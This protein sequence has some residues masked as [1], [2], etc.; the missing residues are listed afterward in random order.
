MI[1]HR[2][3]FV[4]VSAAVLGLVAV[5][6]VGPAVPASADPPGLVIEGETT[7]SDSSDKS[8]K[9]NCPGGTVVTGG[10]GYL[11]TSQAAEPFVALDRLEPAGDGTGFTATMREVAVYPGTW[12]HTA[13]A[14]C[15]PEPPGWAV[16]SNTGANQQQYVTTPTCGTGRN[17]IGI[18][19]RINGGSGEVILEDLTPSFDLE[20]VTV[21]GVAIPGGDDD[22]WTVTAYAVCA[23]TPPGLERIAFPV[24]QDSSAE[25]TAVKSCPAG[26]ALYGAG[27]AVNNGDGN[28]LLNGVNIA[29][30][31]TVRAWAHE[32]TGGYGS[33]WNLT[34]YGICGS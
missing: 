2:Q 34:A 1:V 3:V 24:P 26:K 32:I 27:A 10:G 13:L 5:L 22:S 16:L 23:N 18:G 19:G 11:T 14:V 20:T 12:R 33:N 7:I 29:P 30:L 17:V 8:I 9:A 15:A 21:R 6:A 31:D 4:G 28:V 25:K